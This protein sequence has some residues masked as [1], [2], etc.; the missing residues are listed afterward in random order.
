MAVRKKEVG[1]ALGDGKSGTVGPEDNP[2]HFHIGGNLLRARHNAICH[3]ECDWWKWIF[4]VTAV[5][6][7]KEVLQCGSQFLQCKKILTEVGDAAVVLR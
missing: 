7:A 2:G 1:V 6:D 3:D 5:A 4:V